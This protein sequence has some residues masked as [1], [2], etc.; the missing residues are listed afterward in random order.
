MSSNTQNDHEHVAEQI[1]EH[2]YEFSK[3]FLEEKIIPENPNLTDDQK[4]FI[5][6]KMMRQLLIK[7]IME[8]MEKSKNKARV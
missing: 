4:L 7:N 5:K 8:E 3:K 1:I 2:G 6:E